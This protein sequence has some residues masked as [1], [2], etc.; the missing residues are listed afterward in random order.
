MIL[1]YRNTYP[2]IDPTAWVAPS[3]EVIGDVT[4]GAESSIWFQSVV[5]GDVHWIRIGNRTN[6]QDLTICHVTRQTHPL[7]IGD[8]VTVGHRVILHGC[9]LGNRI[10]VGMGSI[11]MDASVIGDD[12]IIGA[13]SLVTEQTVIEPGTLALGS[14]A[15][16]KRKLTLDELE[17]LKRSAA[18]YTAYRLEYQKSNPLS[19]NHLE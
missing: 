15:R 16:I 14:P 9:T 17:W 13:G 6:I 7:V 18:N 4:I 1:P 19:P 12:V 11:I 2:T 10:L 8:D 5:R 3:A